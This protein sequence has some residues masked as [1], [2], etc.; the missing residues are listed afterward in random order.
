MHKGSAEEVLN[1]VEDIL[2]SNGQADCKA[3]ICDV[4][5]QIC[6]KN[7]TTQ[8]EIQRI[9]DIKEAK[10]EVDNV[11]EERDPQ[12]SCNFLTCTGSILG[13]FDI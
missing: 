7:E 13:E 5:P 1:C 9:S 4:F 11:G 12:K 3:C 6:Q 8:T 10:V 2:N